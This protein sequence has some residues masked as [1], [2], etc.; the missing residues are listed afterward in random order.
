M[1]DLVLRFGAL[2]VLIA[3]ALEYDVTLILAGVAVHLGLLEFPVVVAAGAVGGVA[4]DS[5]FF[6]IGRWGSAVI[7]RWEDR[8]RIAP[9]VERL[10]ET[11]PWEIVLARFVY[12]TRFPSGLFW[13]GRGL[14]WPT[15]AA[16]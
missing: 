6:A 11:G 5:L 8:A 7:L 10:A 9:L 15:F 2:A 13:G 1:E 16:A 4:G 12:G 3:A 14:G